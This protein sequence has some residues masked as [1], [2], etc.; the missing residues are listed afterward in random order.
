MFQEVELV[1]LAYLTAKAHGLEEQAQ[2][3]LEM[4]GVQEGDVKLPR[5]GGGGVGKTPR[6]VVEG[7]R[8]NWPVRRTGASSFEKA[9][10]ADGA[11]EGVGQETNGHAGA[12][13]GDLLAEEEAPRNGHLADG[14]G[15]DDEEE[16]AGWDLGDDGV[17][18][19]ETE[20]LVDVSAESA[21]GAGSSEADLWTRNSPLAADHAAAGSFESAMNL[22]NRQVGAVHFAPLEER[23]LEIYTASRTFLPANAGMPPL[24]NFV[25]RSVGEAD[26]RKVLPLVPRD[27]E[28]VVQG[29]VAAGKN[30]MKANRLEDGLATFRSALRLLLVNA[31]ASPAQAAEAQEAVRL[32]REYVLAMSIELERRR[33]VGSAADVSGLEEGARKRALELSAYF[34]VPRM[35]PQHRTLAVFSAMNFAVKNRQMG[36]AL[37]FANELIARGTNAKFKETARKIKATAER[38][39]VD[40]LAL[41]YD[42]HTAFDVCA[43]SFTPIYEGDA[44]ATCG[45]DGSKY[46][47]KYRGTVCKVCGVCEVGKGGSGY[48][49]TV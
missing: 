41:A 36:T 5:M 42:A 26:A 24:I 6:V 10:L 20:D 16:A 15:E 30:A 27:V 43:A 40:A 11:E 21:G 18:E 48:R 19:A 12:D 13:E 1:P 14:G 25:R 2:G 17:P 28:S 45:F 32:A 3:I 37:G 46:L 35:E 23:F 29:E 22:L 39:P 33:L 38:N 49:L 47:P 34:T 4:S 31:A 8:R 9:L 7:F 44:S